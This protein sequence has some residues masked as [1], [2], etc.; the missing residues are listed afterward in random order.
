MSP[1][2]E[3]VLLRADRDRLPDPV[4]FD[5]GDLSVPRGVVGGEVMPLRLGDPAG[6]VYVNADGLRLRLP[7]NPRASLLVAAATPARRGSALLGNV[8]LVGPADDEG[9][10]TSVA[11][12]YR[13]VL[14]EDPERV[15][16]ELTVPGDEAPWLPGENTFTDPFLAYTTALRFATAFPET[17]IRLLPA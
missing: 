10:D 9:G 14:L 5:A 1:S 11:Q 17:T 15:C 16:V 13:A 2:I 7:V 4:T 12:D 8:L 3:G 6:T